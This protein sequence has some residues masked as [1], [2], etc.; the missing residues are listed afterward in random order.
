MHKAGLEAEAA[1]DVAHVTINSKATGVVFFLL[2][3]SSMQRND[4][5]LGSG[6]WKV[7]L[8]QRLE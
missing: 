3:A 1:L 2:Q 4:Q 8:A 6:R 7:I 5:R